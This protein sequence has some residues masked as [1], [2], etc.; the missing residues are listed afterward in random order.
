MRSMR[1]LIVDD[2]P[3]VR[4][5]LRSSLALFPDV[6]VIGECQDGV[7]AVAAMLREKPDVVFLDI[8][9]PGL[10]GLEALSLLGADRPPVIIVVTAFDDRAIEAFEHHAVHYLLKPFDRPRLAEAVARARARL[11]E[12]PARSAHAPA[13]GRGRAR[14]EYLSR[15]PVRLGHHVTL[16]PVSEITW[17]EA[18]DNY[19]AIH[20]GSQ[21]YLVRD[22]LKALELRLDPKSFARIHRSV[23]VNLERIAELT[24]HRSGDYTVRLRTGELLTLSR[25][26]RARFEALL[27]RPVSR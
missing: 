2:E 11:G 18:R 4:E 21:R 8:R 20:T 10:D 13:P 16:V 14:P 27:G 5:G 25:S 9:M 24:A 19:V 1:T 23:V 7:E 12:E 17:L 26:Y 6:Q 3:L 22:T 15:I